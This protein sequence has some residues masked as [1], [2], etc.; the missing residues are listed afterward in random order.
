MAI[1]VYRGSISRIEN[2][3]RIVSDIELKGIAEV[4]KVPIEE[5]FEGE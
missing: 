4:L 3:S 1:Y 2:G 5:L